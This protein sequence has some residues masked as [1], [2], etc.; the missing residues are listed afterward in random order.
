MAKGK[1]KIG[2]IITI[3]LII[4]MAVVGV[5]ALICSLIKA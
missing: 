4:F 5:A 2:L 1:K 3:I